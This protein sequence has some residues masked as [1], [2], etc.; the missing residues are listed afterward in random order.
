MDNQSVPG[1][2]GH[3]EPGVDNS[4][5]EQVTDTTAQQQPSQGQAPEAQPPQKDFTSAVFLL[6]VAEEE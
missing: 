4:S 6:G 3:L 2:R 1:Y 5:Q